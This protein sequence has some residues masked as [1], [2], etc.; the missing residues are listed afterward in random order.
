M[1]REKKIYSYR[2]RNQNLCTNELNRGTFAE[3]IF[4]NI[5]AFLLTVPIVILLM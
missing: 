2:Q 5:A 3:T 1:S 4:A